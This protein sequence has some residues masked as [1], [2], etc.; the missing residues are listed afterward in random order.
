MYILPAQK[1]IDKIEWDK[2]KYC[3]FLKKSKKIDKLYYK[4][5]ENISNK[6]HMTDKAV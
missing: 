1:K 3:S 4:I 5:K 2:Q 6:S